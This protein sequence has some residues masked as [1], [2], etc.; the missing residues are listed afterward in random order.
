[1]ANDQ[2]T[3][4][5]ATP[6]QLQFTSE[7]E[8]GVQ[9]RHR[10]RNRRQFELPYWP[11]HLALSWIG[12]R[13]ETD[14]INELL[15]AVQSGQIHGIRAGA[16]MTPDAWAAS[17]P[18]AMPTEVHFARS[19]ILHVWPQHE[20]TPVSAE[21]ACERWLRDLCLKDSGGDV[22]RQGKGHWRTIAI[23]R[24]DES[25]NQRTHRVSGRGFDRAW[26]VVAKDYPIISAVGKRSGPRL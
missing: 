10:T 3:H 4:K 12:Q 23:A 18:G 15:R 19:D 22:A 20:Q 2:P 8:R 9:D 6:A 7:Y 17:R 25:S 11:L 14:P 13:R 26:A 24:K 16:R 5:P 21:A 1:M